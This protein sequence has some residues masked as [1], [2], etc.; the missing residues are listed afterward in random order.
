MRVDPTSPD[1]RVLTFVTKMA[2]YANATL[3]EKDGRDHVTEETYVRTNGRNETTTRRF[4][5]GRAV[6]RACGGDHLP[7]S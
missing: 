3:P 7:R 4:S 6:A 1:L 5:S 2:V